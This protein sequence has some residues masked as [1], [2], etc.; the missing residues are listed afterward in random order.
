MLGP[1]TCFGDANAL[2][3]AA[4]VLVSLWEF[5]VE[6]L[7]QEQWQGWLGLGRCSEQRLSPFLNFSEL[8]REQSFVRAGS[9]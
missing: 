6:W 4:G 8:F 5:E 1:G 2:A 3:G 7:V 9:C